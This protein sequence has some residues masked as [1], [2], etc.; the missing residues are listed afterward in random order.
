MMVA[1]CRA[2][3]FSRF[4]PLSV[5][6][7]PLGGMARHLVWLTHYHVRPVSSEFDA[8]I[9]TRRLDPSTRIA[10]GISCPSVV[11]PSGGRRRSR[12]VPLKLLPSSRITSSCRRRG[13]RANPFPV[14]SP[15]RDGRL[16]LCGVG[17]SHCKA[18][19][20]TSERLRRSFVF[21][22]GLTLR[23]AARTGTFCA[24]R[25]YHY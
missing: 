17:V 24:G 4:S 10:Q 2:R 9:Q 11:S 8:K 21:K 15:V 1:D 25:I 16:G 6:R 13:G 18:E 22:C 7:S 3:Q 14:Q 20:P 23:L 19:P 12:R 5:A